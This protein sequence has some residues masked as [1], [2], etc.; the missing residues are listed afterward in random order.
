M[1]FLWKGNPMNR[2]LPLIL[3][4]MSSL[5]FGAC[6]PTGSESLPS[7]SSNSSSQNSTSSGTS[8]LT[9]EQEKPWVVT[10]DL[11]HS[12]A[13]SLNPIEVADGAKI[14]PPTNGFAPEGD[15]FLGWFKDPESL[16]PWVFSKDVVT[17]NRTLYGG[18]QSILNG[19]SSSSEDPSDSGDSYD[20]YDSDFY[21]VVV[22]VTFNGNYPSA[23]VTLKKVPVQST[24]RAPSLTRE[25]YALTSWSETPSGNVPFDFQTL[26][27]APLTL[28]AQWAALTAYVVTLNL[29]YTGAPTPTTVTAYGGLRLARPTSP[30]REH[31][32]FLG[33][34]KEASGTNA[35]NF[36]SDLISGDVTLFARWSRLA[37][38]GVYVRVSD[39][40]AQNDATFVLWCGSE[41][42]NATSVAT[43]VPNEYYFDHVATTYLALKRYVGTSMV[44]QVYGIAPSGGWGTQWNLITVRSSTANNNSQ[45]DASTGLY[46]DLSLRDNSIDENLVLRTVT[47]DLAY[48]GAATPTTKTI[49]DG[50]SVTAPTNPTRTGYNFLGWST[51][52]GGALFDFS[53]PISADTT[54]LAQWQEKPAPVV[55]NV[56]FD[57]NYEGG[58]SPVS[59]NATV[60]ELL[61]APSGITRSGYTLA[62]WY[63]DAA[64]T[65]AWNFATDTVSG[66]MT[67]YAKWS[68]AS[69]TRTD[70]V[71]ILMNDAW[72]A[73]NA[74]FDLYYSV[75]P[76]GGVQ[77]VTGT[78]T[79][80][81]KEYFFNQILGSGPVILRRKV[82]GTQV[83]QIYDIATWTS[84]GHDYRDFG[85]GWNRIVLA[86][87]LAGNVSNQA[88][89]SSILTLDL[90]PANGV[91]GRIRLVPPMRRKEVIFHA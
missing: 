2:K 32:D 38:P 33:W 42:V 4:T 87:G 71:Y 64:L 27:T 76:S 90:R 36:S 83:A 79:G 78:A 30:I 6:T 60:G 19:H 72:I 66:S 23:P 25:G 70:G 10:F 53:T 11:N 84:S 81:A 28:Y 63:R 9:S 13:P 29:N 46:V 37:L 26:I 31:Y 58:G 18:W 75:V 68:T 40:W 24:V 43:G 34:Y 39:L 48:D 59:A 85:T 62:G 74:T 12:D 88:A 8:S 15:T 1:A 7:F 73:D 16:V 89:S 22:D 67:L 17:A 41:T 49:L 14:N 77:T 65:T 86:S 44:G 69:T 54:L 55:V 52:Q 20:Y 21:P 80:V 51:S 5:L 35:W 3:L 82:S 91:S 45:L 57:S 56:L 61:S 47:F 50:T